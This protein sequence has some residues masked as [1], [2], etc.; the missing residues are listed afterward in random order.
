MIQGTLVMIQGTLVMIQGT[1]AVLHRNRSRVGDGRVR[2]QL[3]EARLRRLRPR[4]ANQGGLTDIMGGFTEKSASASC[5]NYWPQYLPATG[6]DS[7]R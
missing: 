5:T 3:P 2:H 4:Y 7:R 6:V 1:L